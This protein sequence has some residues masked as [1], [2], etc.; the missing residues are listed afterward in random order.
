MV[1]NCQNGDSEGW[2][3]SFPQLVEWGGG[4]VLALVSVLALLQ[5]AGVGQ[6]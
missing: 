6:P 2:M 4:R 5:G 1:Q 3:P